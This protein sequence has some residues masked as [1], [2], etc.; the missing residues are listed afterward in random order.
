[1]PWESG[2]DSLPASREFVV[3]CW[4]LQTVRTPDQIWQNVGPDPDP[5]HLISW[6]KSKNVI[7]FDQSEW[8]SEAEFEQS[9]RNNESEKR[10]KSSQSQEMSQS[11]ASDQLQHREEKM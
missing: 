2:L 3:C 1:M 4:S 11:Q 8:A 6:K 7:W 5:N 9:M 10:W